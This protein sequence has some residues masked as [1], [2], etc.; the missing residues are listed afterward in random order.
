M[1]SISNKHEEFFDYLI[2]NAENFHRGTLIAKDV[3]TNTAN[4]SMYMKDIAQLEHTSDKI[5]EDVIMKLCRVFITPID[6]EDF[7]KLTCQL[8]DCIDQLH[9]SL[10]RIS[11]Y[12]IKTMTPAAVDIVDQ[13][14]LMGKEL[15]DIFS[16]LKNIDKNEAELMERANRLS[17]IE[18]EV[19]NIYRR[20]NFP[21]LQRRN[22]PARHHPLERRAGH[23]GRHVGRSGRARQYHKRGDDEVC[24]IPR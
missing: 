7:Y 9:G 21:H 6:R 5:N 15:K 19:D 2:E 14:E 10:M 20:E 23:A 11:L 16:L 22:G 4:I 12:H 8:E 18:T 24:L 13:L 3:M 1:F 17:K